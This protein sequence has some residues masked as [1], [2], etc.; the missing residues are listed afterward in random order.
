MARAGRVSKKDDRSGKDAKE[1]G[2][3]EVT[4][5]TEE[6]KFPGGCIRSYYTGTVQ[7][8]KFS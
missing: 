6:R 1:L 3:E 8:L 2:S 4:E 7:V 5:K